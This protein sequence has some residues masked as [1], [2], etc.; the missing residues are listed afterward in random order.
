MHTDST[1]VTV[2]AVVFIRNE[3]RNCHRVVVR[4][5][6]LK[7]WWREKDWKA[8]KYRQRKHI[9]RELWWDEEVPKSNGSGALC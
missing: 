7:H 5:H 2:V 3:A 8:L 4:G 9:V 1:G 6:Y